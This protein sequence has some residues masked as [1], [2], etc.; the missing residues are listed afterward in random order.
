[1]VSADTLINIETCE[2]ILKKINALKN[3]I[4]DSQLKTDKIIE[5]IYDAEAIVLHDLEIFKKKNNE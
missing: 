2:E 1:M 4:P 3:E 5:Y